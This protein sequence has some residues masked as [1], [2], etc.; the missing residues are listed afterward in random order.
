ML[1]S[2]VLFLEKIDIEELLKSEKR[3]GQYVQKEQEELEKRDKQK[4]INS[5][6]KFK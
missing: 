5:N 2:I 6:S 1:N 4:K 3:I